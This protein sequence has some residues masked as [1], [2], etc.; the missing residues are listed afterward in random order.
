MVRAAASN[1]ST[2]NCFVEKERA[3]LKLVMVPS[4]SDF[5]FHFMHLVKIKI[6]MLECKDLTL[7][8]CT[9]SLC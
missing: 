6:L 7:Q 8:G 3:E 2:M 1:A 4:L 9:Y 5:I